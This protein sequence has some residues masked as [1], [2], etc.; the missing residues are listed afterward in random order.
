M[1]ERTLLAGLWLRMAVAAILGLAGIV[2]IIGTELGFV[3]AMAFFVVHLSPYFAALVFAMALCFGSVAALWWL[4]TTALRVVVSPGV[5]SERIDSKGVDDLVARIGAVLWNPS[6]REFLPL[7]G[8]LVGVSLGLVTMSVV[9]KVLLDVPVAPFS[10]AVATVLVG[11]HMS[12][13]VYTEL[14]GSAGSVQRDIEDNYTIV[15]DS[16]REQRVEG[17]LRR[18]AQQLNAP[19]PEV[20]IGASVTPQ[21]ATVGYRPDQSVLVVSRGLLDRL[22]GPQLDGVL[23][24]ELAHLENRDGAVLTALSLPMAKARTLSDQFLKPGGDAAFFVLLVAPPVYAVSR[25]SVAVVARYREYVADYGAA[26]L[27]G[28]PAA[29]ASALETLDEASAGRPQEDL[30]ER[31]S[32][33][34]FGIVPPPWRERKVLDGAIRFFYRRILGTHPPTESRIERL[35]QYGKLSPLKDAQHKT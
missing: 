29:L 2:V 10:I 12:Y 6:P 13:I 26:K 27:T 7:I 16:E 35:Q 32:T 14:S 28:D 3:A 24:H 8:A 22:D 4:T 11:G 33:A 19:V 31:H 5:L 1:G 15:A 9:V 21:A 25:L 34:A 18:L 17:R 23:A 20:E 30:R